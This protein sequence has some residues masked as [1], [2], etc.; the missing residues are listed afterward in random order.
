MPIEDILGLDGRVA[1]VTGAASGYGKATA[2]LLAKFG[3]HVVA[4]DINEPG[5]DALIVNLERPAHHLPLRADISDVSQCEQLV[6][7][8][9]KRY[10]RLD[11][12]VNAAAVLQPAN[13]EE[14]DE[15]LWNRTLDVNLKSQYFL[16]RAA[17]RPMKEAQWGRIINFI[18]TAGI[19]GGTLPASVYGISKAGVIAMTKSFARAFGRDNI[20]VNAISP[21]TLRT[22]LFRRGMSDA[23]LT[24]VS[25]SYLSSCLFGRW[26]RP[27][28]VAMSVIYLASAMSSC[29]SGH[30]LRADSGAGVLHP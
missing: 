14:V 15:Q 13:I 10:R 11:V 12:L 4:C 16:S 23:E 22:P 20:L 24:A 6:L 1:L 19:T 25:D 28:E 2:E 9:L 17:C 8:T 27:E 30:V 21:A 5:L 7:S 29:V 26:T 3:A 18:S